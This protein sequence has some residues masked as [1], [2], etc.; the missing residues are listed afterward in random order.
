MKNPYKLIWYK[1]GWSESKINSNN[2]KYWE[3][4]AKYNNQK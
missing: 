2:C 1:Q 3:W 4:E